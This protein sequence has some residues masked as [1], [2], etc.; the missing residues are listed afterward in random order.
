[1]HIFAFFSSNYLEVSKKYTTF[2]P[3]FGRVIQKSCPKTA[4]SGS[5]C[6]YIITQRYSVEFLSKLVFARN[7][8][9]RY[10]KNI[11][12]PNVFNIKNK[13]YENFSEQKMAII[14]V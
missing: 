7:S 9:Q 10:V 14:D 5:V 1:M 8:L 6:G 2:A 13:H 3:S 4:T 11:T 12:L